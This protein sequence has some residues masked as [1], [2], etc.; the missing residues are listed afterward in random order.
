LGSFEEFSRIINEIDKNRVSI[1]CHRNAD[2]DALCSAFA[3]KKLLELIIKDLHIEIITPEGASSLTNRVITHFNIKVADR[4]SIQ[5]P[6]LIIVLD[7]GSLIQLSTSMDFV[8]KVRAKKIFID[9]HLKSKQIEEIADLYIIEPESS[10]TCE[11]V[12]QLYKNQNLQPDH[13]TALALIVGIMFDTRHFYLGDGKTF[14]ITSKLLD[15]GVSIPE[16]KEI[17]TKE[18]DISERIARLKACQRLSLYRID[19]KLIVTSKVNSFQSSVSRGLISIGSDAS[20]VAGETVDG[21]KAS[22]RAS[23]KFYNVTGIHLSEMAKEL[24][25]LFHGSGSGHTTAAGLNAEGDIGDF[26]KL[27][28]DKFRNYF[29]E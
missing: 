10:S 11:I 5:D 19:D 6:D 21:F 17:L 29:M 7:T 24:G 9:H 2:P 12:Y 23:Q 25:A 8:K 26:L 1:L 22:M 3:L 16:A 4:E 28:V 14:Q 15:V 18:M 20:V 27:T 13:E